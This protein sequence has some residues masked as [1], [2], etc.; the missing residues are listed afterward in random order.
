[1]PKK[2]ISEKDFK[3]P[4]HIKVTLHR[5][6]RL[7]AQ[8]ALYMEGIED[9]LRF[10][11]FNPEADGENSLRCGD[12]YSL[13]EFECGNDVTEEFCAILEKMKHEGKV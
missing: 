10:H 2:K 9:W 6:A 5:I 4:K 3:V 8:S 7:N 12:G 1:M 11:G 13:E